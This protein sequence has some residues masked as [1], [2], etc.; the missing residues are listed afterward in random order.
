MFERLKHMLVK[1]FIQILR[2]PRMRAV[3]FV[4]PILQLIVFGYAV[5]TD[6][7]KIPTAVADFDESQVTRELVR[8]F[9]GSGYF[10]VVRQVREAQVLQDLLDRGIVKAALQFDPG[11][12]TGLARGRT[13]PL[14]VIVDGTDSNTAGVVMDYANRIVAQYNRETSRSALAQQAIAKGRPKSDDLR[15][16]IGSIDLRTRAWYNPDLQSRNYNVPGVI[17]IIIMLTSL[18]LTSMAIVREREIGTMEQL[19]VTPIRPAELILGKTLP[20]GLIGFFNVA[21]VTA[22]AVFWFQVPIRGNLL[23]LFGATGLYLL[24]TLGIGLFISTVSRTQ[25][26]ALM[27]TFFFYLPAVLLS[28]FM[29]P[30]ANMPVVVQY[31]TYANP[32]RYFL[33]IIR[34]IFLKGNGPEVLWPQMLALLVLGAAVIAA[35][36]LRFRKRME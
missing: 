35:S 3:I 32:L 2:D 21:L 9:E 1:E 5:T 31:L 14:Q 18:L 36:T 12:T 6:I 26:Q 23:L 13:A 16:R 30:I 22:V 20:F 4:T 7:T 33:V 24:S 11:F 8:R 19:M 29:F 15:P 28:G 25:Q 34:G 10:A 27:S 17:A